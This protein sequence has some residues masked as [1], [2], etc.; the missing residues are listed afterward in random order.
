MNNDVF[1]TIF[2]D[3]NG[4]VKRDLNYTFYRLVI[5]H[6]QSGVSDLKFRTR[7]LK[8]YYNCTSLFVFMF[9]L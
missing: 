4:T 8:K 9:R 3:Q 1:K 5:I 2:I 6:L 7:P